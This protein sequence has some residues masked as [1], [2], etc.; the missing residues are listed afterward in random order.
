V[1]SEF[2][3]NLFGLC[4]VL[5]IGGYRMIHWRSNSHGCRRDFTLIAKQWMS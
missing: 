2:Y 4:I 5:F 1:S 3:Y